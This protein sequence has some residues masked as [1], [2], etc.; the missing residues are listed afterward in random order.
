MERDK[1]QR[2]YGVLLGVAGPILMER[3]EMFRKMARFLGPGAAAR[4]LNSQAERAEQALRTI[5]E[6]FNERHG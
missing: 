6:K 1:L 2:E 3:A 4:F 5:G